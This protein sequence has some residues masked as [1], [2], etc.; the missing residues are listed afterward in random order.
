MRI[1]ESMTLSFTHVFGGA[2][3]EACNDK[4][5]TGNSTLESR[6]NTSNGAV[7]TAVDV[8]RIEAIHLF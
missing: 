5:M 1:L 7:E 8:W 3:H 4:A 2:G 6:N